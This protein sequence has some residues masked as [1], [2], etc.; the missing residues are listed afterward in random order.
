MS[1]TPGPGLGGHGGWG[2]PGKHATGNMWVFQWAGIVGAGVVSLT[3]AGKLARPALAL[4]VPT[5][6]VYAATRPINWA[7]Y[8]VYREV[9][10]FAHWARGGEME[11][12]ISITG[13]PFVLPTGVPVV[14]PFLWL[15]IQPSQSSGGGGPG[16]LP[17]L[18][19]PPPSIEETGKLLSNPPI[20]GE[21]ISSPRPS[22]SKKAG[23][24]P[25]YLR[26]IRAGRKYWQ[27]GRKV[28]K[29]SISKHDRCA[30]RAGHSGR[31]SFSGPFHSKGN[32]TSYLKRLHG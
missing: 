15:D 11:I 22:T 32:I 24:C 20:A 26:E 17:N 9:G 16:G 5:R 28:G 2:G 3:V 19:R 27:K 25:Y 8:N 7:A 21:G 13:R 23:Q 14:V 18:H 6:L 12:G 4:Q 29:Y 1:L 10:D 30:K 31:H